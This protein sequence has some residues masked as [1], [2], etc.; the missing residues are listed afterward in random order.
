MQA[1]STSLEAK[2]F[3]QGRNITLVDGRALNKLIQSAREPLPQGRGVDPV[4]VAEPPMVLA[5]V[6]PKCGAGMA[7]RQAK[8]G[9]NAGQ[10]FWGCT[11]Y[12]GCRGTVQMER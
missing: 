5:P 10:Y 8:R 4:P 3:A 6:C 2:T 11:N 1:A 12:P 9:A 7:K